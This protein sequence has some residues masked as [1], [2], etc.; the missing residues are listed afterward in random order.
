M[1]RCFSRHDDVIEWKHFP[2]YW[3][4]V[5][6]IHRSLVNSPQ[7]GQWRGALMYSL[8][9]ALH[10]WL[11]K[12]SWGWRHQRAHYD[13]IVMLKRPVYPVQSISR[14]PIK[15][16][17]FVH[18]GHSAIFTI[19]RHIYQ[20]SI[21]IANSPTTRCGVQNNR[22][23]YCTV[24]HPLHQIPRYAKGRYIYTKTKL[25][26]LDGDG[27]VIVDAIM[28]LITSLAIVYSTVYSFADQR[29]YRCSVS[30]A[31]V[32]GIHRWP[33]NSPHKWPV[34]RK[35]CLFD[36]VIMYDISHE[37]YRRSCECDAWS[38]VYPHESFSHI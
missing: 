17:I 26:A 19:F 13:V 23:P 27:D 8:I 9:C 29:K 10:K 38:S 1:I 11:S 34:T 25:H 28:S 12:Q 20:C 21:L 24:R 35:M 14:Y 4:F 7:K 6:G 22:S 5:W 3:P 37:S 16:Q 31:F 18:L 33:V 2:R 30:L 32:R 36:D 15:P